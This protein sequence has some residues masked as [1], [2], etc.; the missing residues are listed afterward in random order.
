[1]T[2]DPDDLR[3]AAAVR[4]A[5]GSITLNRTA[6]EVTARTLRYAGAI[7]RSRPRRR[8]TILGVAAGIALL[9]VAASIALVNVQQ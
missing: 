3:T 1:M 9:A 4:Q 5:F 8:R 6:E 2:D 7:G